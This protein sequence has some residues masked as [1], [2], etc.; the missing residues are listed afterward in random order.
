MVDKSFSASLTL[1]MAR[2][3]RVKERCAR[4]SQF[5][6]FKFLTRL[7]SLVLLV[8]RMKSLAR[9]IAAIRRSIGPIGVPD[10]SRSARTLA[11]SRQLSRSK[12]TSSKVNTYFS[13]TAQ[14][15][16][17]ALLFSSP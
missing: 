3:L 14:L 2:H 11:Y 7:N 17:L 6:S 12:A 5:S 4:H 16:F 13:T 8:T 9:L 10:V 1:L 15:F